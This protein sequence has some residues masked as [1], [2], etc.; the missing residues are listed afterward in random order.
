M[1]S[2]PRT[3]V[4]SPARKPD[5][6]RRACSVGA[7]SPGLETPQR[8]RRANLSATPPGKTCKASP[9]RQGSATRS[10]ASDELQGAREVSVRQP[11]RDCDQVYN[12]SRRPWDFTSSDMSRYKLKPAEL[13]RKQLLRMSKNQ[14]EAAFQVRRKWSQMQ[15]NI[16][17]YL[18]ESSS[19]RMAASPVFASRVPTGRLP[20]ERKPSLHRRV[21][22]EPRPAPDEVPS[23][24]KGPP[25]DRLDRALEAEISEFLQRNQETSSGSREKYRFLRRADPVRSLQ[26]KTSRDH[27]EPVSLFAGSSEFNGKSSYDSD[28]ELGEIE[29]QA[30][31][32]EAQLAWWSKQRDILRGGSRQ[33]VPKE[34]EESSGELM[35][36]SQWLLPP[37]LDA[38]GGL[39]SKGVQPEAPVK[40]SE[41]P[42]E[43]SASSLSELIAR[44]A[45]ELVAAA[46]QEAN[47]AEQ[48]EPKIAWADTSAEEAQESSALLAVESSAPLVEERSANLLT[49]KSAESSP[50]ATQR[51][52]AIAL[53]EQWASELAASTSQEEARQPAKPNVDVLMTHSE[54]QELLRD[55]G[56]AQETLAKQV[57]D[58][59]ERDCQQEKISL[60]ELSQVFQPRPPEVSNFS[61]LFNVAT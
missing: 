15:E 61:E 60:S 29:D 12:A 46:L 48:P 37:Q 4:S 18:P 32:L 49:E 30:G 10:P 23:A 20:E 44:Q 34:E 19:E 28:S 39:E 45:A 8:R 1:H 16:A 36:C 27:L 21:L 47:V 42:C 58:D 14:D 3:K 11:L 55:A 7:L 13:L 5:C 2:F 56:V 57:F 53:A 54:L 31:Q 22:S 17:P 50:E 40:P 43:E 25:S 24:E 26:K 38:E 59:L 51:S 41:E 52:K 6:Q 33:A 9:S 35:G